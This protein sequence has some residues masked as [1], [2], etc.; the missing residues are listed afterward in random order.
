MDP[1][2]PP[3]DA[4]GR[5][6]RDRVVPFLLLLLFW[7]IL[8]PELSL[9]AF[10]IGVGV[11][12]AVVVFCRDI[13]FTRTELPLYSPRTWPRF[14]LLALRLLL[15]I[16]KANI[17]VAV[18]VLS[19]RL[20][21]RPRFVRIPLAIKGEFTRAVYANCITITPGSLAVEI[22]EQQM[23]VHTLTDQAAEQ[24]NASFVAPALIAI[25]ELGKP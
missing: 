6:L 11:S 23:L 19:P 16:V 3:Q 14:A 8:T 24:L 7:L 22:E 10:V 18:T 20:P 15:E 1:A 4:G 9:A 2:F 21:I 5:S 25:E 12:T 17:E 13:L